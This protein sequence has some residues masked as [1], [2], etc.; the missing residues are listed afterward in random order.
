MKLRKRHKL[1]KPVELCPG[2]KLICTVTERGRAY[3]FTE[4][5]GRKQIVDTI[6]T[7]DVEEPVLGLTSGIG[8][9]FGESER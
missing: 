1:D 9:I 3:M 2:D 8:A 4:F 7:F 6:V 5:I